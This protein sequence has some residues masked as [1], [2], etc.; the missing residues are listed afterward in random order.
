MSQRML[1]DVVSQYLDAGSHRAAS[2]LQLIGGHRE[3]EPIFGIV[4]LL[5]RT[6]VPVEPSAEF[7]AD[8]RVRLLSADIATLPSVAVLQPNRLVIGAVA[9][10]SVVSAA[11]AAYF[12]I[13][14]SRLSRAA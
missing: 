14:R 4:R 8:L 11:A 12:V 5:R 6:L 1:A 3:P 10:G 2:Y 7:V 13:S 9:V